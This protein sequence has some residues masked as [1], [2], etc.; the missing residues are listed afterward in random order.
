MIL[1]R[2]LIV[3]LDASD[4]DLTASADLERLLV[5]AY[6]CAEAIVDMSQV[7]YMDSTCLAK[8]PRLHLERVT[9]R[10]LQPARL[11]IASPGVRRLFEMVNF[12]LLWP[13][14]ESVEAAMDGAALLNGSSRRSAQGDPAG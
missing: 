8:L 6:D 9:K 13:I 3:R 4:W 7:E 11:V 14:Y 5:A 12:D 2:P 1:D 10:G